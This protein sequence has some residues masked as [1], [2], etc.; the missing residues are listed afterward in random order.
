M[1]PES[2]LLFSVVA[3]ARTIAKPFGADCGASEGRGDWLRL[4]LSRERRAMTSD[5]NCGR[6]LSPGA[7][8]DEL[9]PCGYRVRLVGRESFR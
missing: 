8:A 6:D 7:Y 3:V 1:E 4:K 2:S 9:K 5:P